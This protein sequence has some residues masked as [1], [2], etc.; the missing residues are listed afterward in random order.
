METKEQEGADESELQRIKDIIAEPMLE[1]KIKLVTET[2][3]KTGI[4]PVGLMYD[5]LSVGI[6]RLTDNEC[7]QVAREV[8]LLLFDVLV[9]LKKRQ[10]ENKEYSE[11]IKALARNRLPKQP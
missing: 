10:D 9:K 11:R 3:P 6:H 4:N 1:N 2:D 7:T 5:Q 8:S